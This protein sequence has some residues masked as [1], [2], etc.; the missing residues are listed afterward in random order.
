VKLSQQF[1]LPCAFVSVSFFPSKITRSLTSPP[2]NTN[3]SIPIHPE[4]PIIA[5][6]SATDMN[7]YQASKLLAH[8]ACLDWVEQQSFAGKLSFAVVTL[9]P[10]IVVGRHLLQPSPVDPGSSNAHIWDSLFAPEALLPM[11]GV[12]V[13]DVARAHLL[14]LKLANDELG[15]NGQVAEFVIS[16]SDWTWRGIIDFVK[17]KYPWLNITLKDGPSFSVVPKKAE[18]VLG[19]N[20]RSLEDAVGELVDQ[21]IEC[22]GC[23]DSGRS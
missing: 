22:G 20:W 13:R 6:P 7:K 21:Q 10:S 9:H 5:S 19:I 16:A 4:S 2:E 11:A 3:R 8:R 17:R 14:A 23:E 18:T 15:V 1:D 12:D